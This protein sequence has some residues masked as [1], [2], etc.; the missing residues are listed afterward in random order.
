LLMLL[1]I[2]PA[3]VQAVSDI[4]H[5]REPG[6]AR[7]FRLSARRLPQV[8]LAALAICAMILVP[9]LVLVGLPVAIWLVV[10]WQY[11]AQALVFE[12]ELPAWSALE[13][14]AK[15][16]RGRWWKTL[17]SVF[18]FDLMATMPGVLVGFG[19]L[20]IGRTAVGFANGV[21]SVLYAVLIPLAVI[22]VTVMYLDRRGDPIEVTPAAGQ[23]EPGTGARSTAL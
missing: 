2:G 19:L 10:R 16:V 20:T 22:A 4:H 17:F 21:S 8:V 11:F 23:P 9:I 6:V 5:G 18:L 12:K 7:S 3:V 1:V 15:L 13:A 14:S